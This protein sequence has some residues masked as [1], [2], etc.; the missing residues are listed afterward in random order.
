MTVSITEL[1]EGLKSDANVFQ[2]RYKWVFFMI[3]CRLSDEN[4]CLDW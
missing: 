4:P 3:I 1:K 2:S